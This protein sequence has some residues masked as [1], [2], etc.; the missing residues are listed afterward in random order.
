MELGTQTILFSLSWI[1]ESM[2]HSLILLA[3]QDFT[4]W[5]ISECCH[6]SPSFPKVSSTGV[7]WEF[8]KTFAASIGDIPDS[9]MYFP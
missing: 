9:P 6:P 2:S 5:I 3:S 8:W 1:N 4:N 7:G